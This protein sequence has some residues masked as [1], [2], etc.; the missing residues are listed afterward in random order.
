[1]AAKT[2][3][4]NPNHVITNEEIP[5]H[6]A[7]AGNV[8]RNPRSSASADSDANAGSDPGAGNHE[9]TG[10][11]WKE[12]ILAQKKA[13]GSLQ[14]EIDEVS[15][16]IHYL[17]GECVSNC[18]EWNE[19]QQQKQQQVDSMKAQLEE[20]QKRLDDMQEDARRQGFGSSVYDP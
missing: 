18:A 7:V 12:Q 1:V 19:R 9:A 15:N 8:P 6:A 5:E 20:Q 16:S 3:H 2:P 17:G 11:K 4:G 10:E 14:K 13:I